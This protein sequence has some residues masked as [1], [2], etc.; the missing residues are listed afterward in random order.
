MKINKKIII[1]FLAFFFVLAPLLIFAQAKSAKACEVITQIYSRIE[2]RLTQRETQLNEK[3][4]EIGN[5]YAEKNQQRETI[6]GQ[7]REKWDENRQEQ[8]A[9]LQEK[10]QTDSQKQAVIAFVKTITQA[11]KDR[12]AAFDKAISD[13]QKGLQAINKSRVG[14]LSKAVT[15]YKSSV[16]EAF[17]KADQ[18]CESGI[19]IKTIRN[20]LREDLQGVR[21]QYQADIKKFQGNGAEIQ[22][23]V[24]A[25]KEAM[26]KAKDEFKV[27]LDQALA[28]LKAA[29]PN[30]EGEEEEEEEAGLQ[31]AC[32]DS[33]GQI[34]IVSCCKSAGNYPNTCLIGVCG[35]S[36][37]SSKEIKTCNCGEGKCFNG[38]ACV[39]VQ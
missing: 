2:Q 37:E 4:V 1:G 22:K 24:E 20:N 34:A 29:M 14:T 10:A 26:N 35:C 16:K 5:K 30:N 11:V 3:I 18:S 19:A 25:K 27:T 32:L 15:D 28:I 6:L 9:K 33:G 39:T 8:F 31:Q 23:L 13:F 38:T 21:S 7:R 36:L 17:D 12:R